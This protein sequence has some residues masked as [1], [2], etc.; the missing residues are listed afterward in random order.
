[1]TSPSETESRRRLGLPSAAALVVG[2]MI[3]AGVFTTSGY[4]LEDL[5]RRERMIRIDS[6]RRTLWRL[7]DVLFLDGCH[8]ERFLYRHLL[9]AGDSTSHSKSLRFANV[10]V[11]VACATS[12]RRRNLLVRRR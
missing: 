12:A 1:M 10:K 3:G 4:A 8:V 11:S 9:R 6:G 5:G 7:K 2:N